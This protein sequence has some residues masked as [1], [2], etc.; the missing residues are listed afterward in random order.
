MF[1]RQVKDLSRPGQYLAGSFPRN[2]KMSTD[3]AATS[4]YD[5]LREINGLVAVGAGRQGEKDCLYVYVAEGQPSHAGVN[6][7]LVEWIPRRCETN[8]GPATP[9]PAYSRAH[10]KVC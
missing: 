10:L 5:A 6:S 8:E 1:P 7:E 3:A 4:L 2:M 9:W